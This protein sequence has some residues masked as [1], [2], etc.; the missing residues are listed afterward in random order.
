MKSGINNG[1]VASASAMAAAMRK[2][3][4]RNGVIKWRK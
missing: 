1:G 2:H 4:W 3:Q